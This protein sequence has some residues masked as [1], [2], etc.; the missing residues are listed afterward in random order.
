MRDSIFEISRIFA[1]VN[2]QF[3]YSLTEVIEKCNSADYPSWDS[4]LIR[5]VSRKTLSLDI[6]AEK[7]RLNFKIHP[8]LKLGS[9]VSWGTLYMQYMI[10]YHIYSFIE[11]AQ[12]TL[13]QTS[14]HLMSCIL[15]FA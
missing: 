7:G 5:K 6:F 15:K 10:L 4:S 1:R 12:I 3:E 2:L 8:L 11:V 13:R 14:S 9:R